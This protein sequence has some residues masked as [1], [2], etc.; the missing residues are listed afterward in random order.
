MVVAPVAVAAEVAAPAAPQG[1]STKPILTYAQRIKEPSAAPA[2]A[3]AVVHVAPAPVAAA[4][5]VVAAAAA[6]PVTAAPA[7]S[8]PA[9]SKD[10]PKSNANGS[11]W[12]PTGASR[13]VEKEASG[14]SPDKAC[15]R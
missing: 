11:S 8:A 10:K 4:V 1:K 12:A 5:P 14:P 15:G 3:A 7:A 9:A 2:K 6:A 13:F